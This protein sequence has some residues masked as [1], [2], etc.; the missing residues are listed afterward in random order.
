MNDQIIQLGKDNIELNKKIIE[1]LDYIAFS[2]WILIALVTF[3]LLFGGV[4]K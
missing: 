4:I 2:L 1:R 3:S